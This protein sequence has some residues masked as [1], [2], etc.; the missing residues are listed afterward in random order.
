MELD[1]GQDY[2]TKSKILSRGSLR[3]V[4][5][6]RFF[7]LGNICLVIIPS[8]GRSS[9]SVGKIVLIMP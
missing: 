2:S 9:V 5:F 1:I 8:T 6:S 3:M 4:G 7:F